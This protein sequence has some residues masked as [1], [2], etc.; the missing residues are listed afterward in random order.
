MPAPIDRHA[1]AMEQLGESLAALLL[2]CVEREN[3][4]KE[5]AA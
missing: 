2:S 4:E 1:V 5:A 3:E